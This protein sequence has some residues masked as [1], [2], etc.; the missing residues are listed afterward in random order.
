MSIQV[1]H[2][3]C[4]GCGICV[5]VCPVEA[6]QLVD[7]W[8]EIDEASCTQCGAC[9]DACPNAAIT[10]IFAP[11]HST[12]AT[13]QPAIPSQIISVTTPIRQPEVPAPA[14]SLAPL[15]SAALGYLGREVAPR[16]VDVLVAALERRLT[17]PV[18][19]TPTAV[20]IS[21]RAIADQSRGVRRQVRYRRGRNRK[22]NGNCIERR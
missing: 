14:R 12:P 2:D 5:E 22:G 21:S 9:V 15:A 18:T 20:S 4:A 17:R 3:L 10:A 11:V 6:I 13:A 8:A 19:T 1:N 7:Y 16:L